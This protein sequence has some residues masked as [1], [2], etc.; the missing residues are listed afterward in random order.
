M[1]EI[2]EV[3]A[4]NKSVDNFHALPFPGIAPFW[5]SFPPAVFLCDACL[6]RL[7]ELKQCGTCS[8]TTGKNPSAV[9]QVLSPLPFPSFRCFTA[10]LYS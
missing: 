8:I 1:F 9:V 6:L 5:L 3:N 4:V 2:P 7:L 10:L